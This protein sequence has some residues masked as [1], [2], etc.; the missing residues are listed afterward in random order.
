MKYLFAAALVVACL[1]RSAPLTAADGPTIDLMLSLEAKS[2]NTKPLTPADIAHDV[3]Y[4]K[5]SGLE[6]GPIEKVDPA[7]VLFKR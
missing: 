7:G 2:F 4:M 6:F 5:L 1:S 3:D